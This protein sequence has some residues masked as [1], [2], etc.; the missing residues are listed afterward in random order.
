[1]TRKSFNPDLRVGKESG[2]YATSDDSDAESLSFLA[3]DEQGN[4]AFVLPASL[5][6]TLHIDR[7]ADARKEVSNAALA[8]DSANRL[9][10]N[11]DNDHAK[12][13]DDKALPKM[14]AQ[15]EGLTLARS[16]LH[17]STKRIQKII[18]SLQ[19][20]QRTLRY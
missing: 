5:H 19:P 9:S 18:K 1:M 10:S 12:C 3:T 11:T 14:Q 7:E 20:C 13:N 2:L 4:G 6:N 15:L 16:V 17:N 8:E